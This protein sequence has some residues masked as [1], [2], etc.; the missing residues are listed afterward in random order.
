M[1][2][3]TNLGGVNRQQYMPL[4]RPG[5]LFATPAKGGFQKWVCNTFLDGAETWHWG[6]IT[7]VFQG[8]GMT[9]SDRYGISES[10]G[11]GVASG[12]LS[13]YDDKTI[14]I[15]RPR[16]V[17]KLDFSFLNYHIHYLA[18]RYGRAY[19]DFPVFLDIGKWFILR[20]LGIKSKIRKDA[21]FYCQEY[22]VRIWRDIGINLITNDQYPVCKNLEQSTEMKLIYREF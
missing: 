7:R 18:C 10:I 12:L 6:I 20:R 14:R 5:D 9:V 8:E 2:Q 17:D 19:Y 1:V 22:V 3:V 4:L 11:K 13:F 15:Y 21:R 16:E